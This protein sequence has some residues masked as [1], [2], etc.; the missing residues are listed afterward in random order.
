MEASDS[1]LNV[2]I[3]GQ[4]KM[5]YD[6]VG[7]LCEKAEL[8]SLNVVSNFEDET[9]RSAARRSVQRQGR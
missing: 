8:T 4:G 9:L 1:G 6:C 5:A 7:R 3:I 2:T